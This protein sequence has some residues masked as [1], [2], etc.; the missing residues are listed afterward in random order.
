LAKQDRNTL[1]KL[2]L[3]IMQV[4]W[5]RGASNVS[6]VQEG[7]EQELA[8]TTVQT[9][10]NILE[11]KGKLKREL[12]GRAFVYSATVTEAKAS[13]HAVRDL[14]DRMFGGS[15]EDLVMSLIK[16]KQIDPKKIAELSKRLEKEGGEK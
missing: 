1:T 10:L 6:A 16:S 3:Q 11:R 15:S 14:V 9:M 8:Y 12:S 4:I 5:K 2:E 7:L 13:G